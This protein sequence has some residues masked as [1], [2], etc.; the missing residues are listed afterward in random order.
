MKRMSLSSVTLT[1]T[2]MSIGLGAPVQESQDAI[3]GLPASD[4]IG[5]T[6][7][8]GNPSFVGGIANGG[9]TSHGVW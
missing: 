8:W 4:V 7:V 9:S 5:P 2:L 6:D 1:L 3:I